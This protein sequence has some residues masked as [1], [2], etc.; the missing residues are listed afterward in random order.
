MNMKFRTYSSLFLLAFAFG[1]IAISCGPA[2]E[3]RST[4][5]S[6]AKVVQ[7][8]IAYVIRSQMNEAEAPGPMQMMQ[9][10]P[11]NTT[12]ATASLAPTHTHAPGETHNH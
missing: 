9:V 10:A 2:A 7:D 5:M 8:S 4:M 11:A 1:L 6:R 3:D 12:P